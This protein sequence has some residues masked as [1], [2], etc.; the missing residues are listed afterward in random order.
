MESDIVLKTLK[1]EIENY[2]EIKSNDEVINV[3]SEHPF[4][5]ENK[6]WVK[7]KDLKIGDVLKSSSEMN[8]KI[9]SIQLIE[10]KIQVYNI[11]V[12]K[13]HNYFVSN[14]TILV[15]NKSIK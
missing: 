8:T 4:Y 10:S 15:H 1:S 2:F 6:G 7:V 11:E 3:T 13:N 5:V 9:T 14:L 12:K